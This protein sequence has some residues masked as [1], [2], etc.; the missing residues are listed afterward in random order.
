MAAPDTQRQGEAEF[1]LAHPLFNEL[2]D[3]Q[4]RQ[5]ME[6]AVQAA[7]DD[8]NTRRT[9]MMQVQAIRTLRRQLAEIAK[10]TK[11]ARKGAVA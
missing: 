10:P 4:E 9:A 7:P 3:G 8:D 6:T 2:L 1:I 5:A 11:P